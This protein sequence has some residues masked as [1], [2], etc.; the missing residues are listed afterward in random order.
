M[1]L[2]DTNAFIT[3]MHKEIT[4][5]KLTESTKQVMEWED[6]LY[7]SRASLWEMAI[8]V[9]LGRLKLTMSMSEVE[10]GALTYGIEVLPIMGKHLDELIRF[11]FSDHLDNF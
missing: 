11:S 2:L 3:L 4:G 9:K 10:K 8:G 7:L 5:A 6:V 1:Y